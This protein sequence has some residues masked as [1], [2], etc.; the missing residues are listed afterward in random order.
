MPVTK[1]EI[2]S[3]T[4]YANGQVF[5][6]AGAYEQLDGVFHFAVDPKNAANETIADLELAPTDSDGLVRF[7]RTFAYC[8]RSTQNWATAA[9]SWTSPTGEATGHQNINSGPDQSPDAPI[10]PGNGFLMREGYSIVW[11]AW[12]H[13]VPDVPGMLRVDVPDAVTPDGPV[14]G[15][16]VVTFQLN[17]P[18]QVEFL[19]SRNHR[20]YTASDVSEQAAVMTVQEHEDGPEQIIQGTNGHLPGWRTAS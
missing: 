20:A 11:C 2:K 14:S 7:C 19:S 6:Y 8:S 5:G 16:I 4:S 17:A 13:D 15:K 1:M 10:D 3:R 12:Q 18:S 9:S